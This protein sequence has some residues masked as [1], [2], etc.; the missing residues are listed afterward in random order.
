MT[1]D[2]RDENKTEGP[3]AR[4]TT[5]LPEGKKHDHLDKKAA[6]DRQEALIDEGVDESFPA[7]D[8]PSVKR[9]T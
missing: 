3:A 6:E 8:P 2:T 4:R 7:S 1:D 9:I 5:P